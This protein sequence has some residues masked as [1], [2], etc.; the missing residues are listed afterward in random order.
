MKERMN[1][2]VRKG[3][4][5]EPSCAKYLTLCES[6]QRSGLSWGRRL[7]SCCFSPCSPPA[8]RHFHKGGPPVPLLS[9]PLPFFLST[10]SCSLSLSLQFLRSLSHSLVPFS[11]CMFLFHMH[12]LFF[13]SVS[14]SGSHLC[15]SLIY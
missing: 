3:E 1:E 6:L 8:S 14:L 9:P 12:F 5:C 10:L 7:Q 13:L 15:Y 2:G 4:K 11:P